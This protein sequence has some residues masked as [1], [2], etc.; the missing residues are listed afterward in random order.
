M[1]RHRFT[2][3][4]PGRPKGSVNKAKLAYNALLKDIAE[5]EE[6]QAS[7]RARAIQGDP[8]I[9]RE[10]ANRVGGPVPRVM[11][12]DTPAPLIVDIVLGPDEPA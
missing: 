2:K 12:I 3:A 5:S 11:Q 9:D 8:T 7:F 1:A 4:G 6:Y 10:I